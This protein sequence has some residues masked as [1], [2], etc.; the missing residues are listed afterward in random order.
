ML[1][2]PSV[3]SVAFYY[4]AAVRGHSAEIRRECRGHDCPLTYFTSVHANMFKPTQSSVFTSVLLFLVPQTHHTPS[5]YLFVFF[6]HMSRPSFVLSFSCPLL[7]SHSIACPLSAPVLISLLWLD[8]PRLS[9]YHLMHKVALQKDVVFYFFV[10][11]HFL[12][13]CPVTPLFFFFL[14]SFLVYCIPDNKWSSGEV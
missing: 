9:S 11:S 7:L 1:D 14:G 10:L 2:H 3:L 5:T 12:L 6:C 4:S 13:A 8:S